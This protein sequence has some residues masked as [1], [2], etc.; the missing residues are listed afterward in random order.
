MK[1]FIL[2]TSLVV[3]CLITCLSYIPLAAQDSTVLMR[4]MNENI[5]LS[6]KSIN[7][8]SKG[9]IDFEVFR[10]AR[11]KKKKEGEEDDKNKKNGT[12]YVSE[13]YKQDPDSDG[14]AGNADKCPSTP[15]KVW[16]YLGRKD[17]VLLYVHNDILVLNTKDTVYAYVDPTGCFPDQDKDG[18]PN[19]NDACPDSPKNTKVDKF[20]CPPLD[21]DGDGIPDE[22][23]KCPDVPGIPKYQGCPPPDRDKDG[24]PDSEDVCIDVPGTVKN[25]GCPEVITETEVEILKAASKVQF[26]PTS[27]TILSDYYDEL[28]R[29]AEL[30]NKY[31]NSTIR[32]EGHTDSDGPDD[33]NQTLSVQRANAVKDYLTNKG[34]FST[35]IEA[36]GF[37]E[38]VP[39]DTNETTQGKL[40]NRRV[41]MN[42]IGKK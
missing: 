19:F 31:P 12:V 21:R 33:Y 7:K 2:K 14:I 13:Y 32:L 15:L 41:E 36:T 16:I 5:D 42:I 11:T 6:F 35:R 22:Q 29:V 40:N 27:A 18:V 17:S 3:L 38:T 4:M 24:V 30:L 8:G 20:G 23:D 10:V 28:D 34:I 37:G 39:I 25:K 1:I 26:T 9:G